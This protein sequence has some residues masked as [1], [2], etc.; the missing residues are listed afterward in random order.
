MSE[1]IWS[2]TVKFPE[3]APLRGDLAVDAAVIGGGLAGILT[4][5]FLREA[6]LRAVVLEAARVGSGQ[7]KNT[8]AKITSQHSLVYHRLTERFGEE[9][10]RQYA[11]A[12]Q[13][14]IAEYR[15]L[16]GSQR[17]A[18]EWADCPAYLYSTAEREPLAREFE[19]A[20]KLGIDAS[21]CSETELPFPV[22]AALR[23]DHQARFHPLKFLRAVADPLE[24]YE[25]TRVTA[26]EENR[27]VTDRGTVTAG[28]IIFACHYPFQNFPGYYFMRMHQERSY[29]I[30]LENTARLEGMYL[31]VD[32]DGLS[33]RPDGGLLLL[34]GGS[35]R[36]GE[37]SAGGQYRKLREAAGRYWPGSREAAH[38]SAQDCMTLDGI[39]Y[40]GR[41]SA[42]TP[43]WYVATGF[44]KWGMTSAMVSARMISDL[45][46]KGETPWEPVFSPQRFTP[47]AS[48][49]TLMQETAQ[50][51]KGLTRRIFTPPQA[52][53]EALPCGHGGV[54]ECGGEKLGVYKDGQGE[55]FVVSIRCP[56]LGCQLEWN[57]DERSW[58]CPCHGSRF[59]YRGNLIDNP[60]QEDLEHE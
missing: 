56:H 2:K 10:A 44:Q 46:V 59:D 9:K 39:P 8:T 4:A 21:Y 23:F 1:S 52:D 13:Q 19:T 32:Q 5:H 3:R 58:D 60:A 16:I 34:G 29:V 40:I 30:A 18:C 36:T 22:A 42:S 15:H 48:A 49:R 28:H 14:A 53:I 43:S 27:V 33:L 31:G 41:F 45:I 50:A 54:V 24:V 55:T 38:W 25:L 37:N 26:A 47:S 51:A 35:H 20:K 57:P 17:I 7:T 12:N 11:Q 6:G